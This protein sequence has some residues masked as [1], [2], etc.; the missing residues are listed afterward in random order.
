MLQEKTK[1]VKG[2]QTGKIKSPGS[3]T[4]RSRSQSLPILISVNYVWSNSSKNIITLNAWYYFMSA[5]YKTK[6]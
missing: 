3:A 1:Y 5:V 4:T 2:V 6:N